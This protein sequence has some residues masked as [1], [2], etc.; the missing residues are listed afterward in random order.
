MYKFRNTVRAGNIGS[1]DRLDVPA[2]RDEVQHID[3]GHINRI[4]TT[5]Y[6]YIDRRSIR[7]AV[8]VR[9][10]ICERIRTDKAQRFYAMSS[11]MVILKC[12]PAGP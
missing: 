12:Y 3:V 6:R 9:K 2:G 8:A 5:V 7:S 1:R 11:L 4:R 10:R